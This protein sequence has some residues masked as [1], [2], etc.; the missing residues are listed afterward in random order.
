MLCSKVAGTLAVLPYR[1]YFVSTADAG[2]DVTVY[3]G[4]D[5]SIEKI[6]GD[7]ID[8]FNNGLIYDVYGRRVIEPVKGQIYIINGK[9]VMF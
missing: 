6:S 4:N 5:T 8:G 2:S 7:D 1:A 3:L 9:K